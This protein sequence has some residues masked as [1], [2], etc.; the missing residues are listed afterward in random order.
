MTHVRR[1]RRL[2]TDNEKVGRKLEELASTK[3]WRLPEGNPGRVG[4]FEAAM[5]ARTHANF[6][7]SQI[8]YHEATLAQYRAQ[9]SGNGDPALKRTLRGA[10]PGFEKN[11]D[12]LLTLKP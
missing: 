2:G 9:L 3:G 11:L 6:I 8:S 1:K 4:S 10:L 5:P 7:I 12:L